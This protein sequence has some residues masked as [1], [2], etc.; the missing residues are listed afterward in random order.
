MERQ[1][2]W[3]PGYV[4]TV[5]A[6]V[7]P[8]LAL[9]FSY[10]PAVDWFNALHNSKTI[11]ASPNSAPTLPVTG[12]EPVPDGP[13]FPWWAFVVIVTVMFMTLFLWLAG[14]KNILAISSRA[15]ANAAERRARSYTFDAD[16]HQ[17]LDEGKSA[18]RLRGLAGSFARTAL[19]LK[20]T[21]QV[22]DRIE[23]AGAKLDLPPVGAD[24]SFANAE[25]CEG[26]PPRLDS[27]TEE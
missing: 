27:L 18:K 5:I 3:K 25:Q 6:F 19:A 13:G 16:V 11:E 2:K 4:T 12:L 14:Y 24:E 22:L 23:S 15:T 10:R 21:S 26:M 1:G 7:V 8:V 9:V 20:G 17:R